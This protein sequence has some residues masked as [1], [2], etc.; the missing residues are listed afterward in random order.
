[1]RRCLRDGTFSRFVTDRRTDT[2]PLHLPRLDSVT[3]LTVKSLAV[4]TVNLPDA[5][6]LSAERSLGRRR[7]SPELYTVVICCSGR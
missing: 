4:S 1:M 5:V 7:A 6:A 2:G 3:R